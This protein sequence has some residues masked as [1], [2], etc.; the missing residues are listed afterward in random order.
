MN[1]NQW[2]AVYHFC[3]DN[4]FERPSELF[5]YLAGRGV[6]GKRERVEDLGNYPK[7]DT[8]DAMKIWLLEN[9]L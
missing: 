1:K 4:G 6:V 9:A 5:S 2:K 3:E 7:E 8:Y